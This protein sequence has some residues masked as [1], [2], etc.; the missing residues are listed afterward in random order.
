MGVRQIRQVSTDSTGTQRR[1][2]KFVVVMF[3][4]LVVILVGRGL[5]LWVPDGRAEKSV[6]FVIVLG[7]LLFVIGELKRNTE[8]LIRFF[9]EKISKRR[10]RVSRS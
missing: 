3:A 1:M 5:G 8:E 7:A 6:S 9:R 4:S 10:S 2:L